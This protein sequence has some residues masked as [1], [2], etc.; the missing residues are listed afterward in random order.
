MTQKWKPVIT[1]DAIAVV[2]SAEKATKILQSTANPHLQTRAD[3][4]IPVEYF[5]PAHRR[6]VVHLDVE[7][8]HVI[9]QT[10][11]EYRIVASRFGLPPLP[12]PPPNPLTSPKN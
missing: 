4:T 12:P 8:H 6:L 1:R 2:G 5:N 11:E 3:T 9:L 10:A 7:S